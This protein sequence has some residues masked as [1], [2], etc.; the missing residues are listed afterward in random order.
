MRDDLELRSS[1][2]C[3]ARGFVLTS[4]QIAVNQE[5]HCVGLEEHV[6]WKISAGLTCLDRFLPKPDACEDMG[7]K[8]GGMRRFR[9]DSAHA[10]SGVDS[11]G[12]ERRMIVTVKQV[13]GDAGMIRIFT[14]QSL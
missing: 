1:F 14:E 8:L 13:V 4:L 7:R 10:A 6:V 2:Q 11:S 3:L 9:C 12:C 5:V